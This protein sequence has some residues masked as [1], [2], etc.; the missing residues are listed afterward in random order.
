MKK[1]L[2]L[3][4]LSLST[5]VFADSAAI[6][7]CYQAGFSTTDAVNKCIYSG[8]EASTI[9]TCIEVGFNRA[10]DLNECIGSKQSVARI[11]SCSLSGIETASAMNRCIKRTTLRFEG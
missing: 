1:I 2:I 8:A 6:V 9:K 7:A 5:S 3:I 4:A 11:R 10:S